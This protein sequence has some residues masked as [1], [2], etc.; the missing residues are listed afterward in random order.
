MTG[1]KGVVSDTLDSLSFWVSWSWTY[2]LMLWFLLIM[3]LIWFLRA[4]LR[5]HENLDQLGFFMNSLTPKFYVALTGTSSVISGIILIFEWW[6]FH[7]HGN[8]LIE[9]LALTYVAPFIGGIDLPE[10]PAQ[11]ECKVWRNPMNL[12]RGCEYFK[13]MQ[14]TGN[15]PLTHYDMNLTAQDQQMFFCP[16]VAGAGDKGDELM[17]LAWRTVDTEK[18]IELALQAVNGNSNCA[19]AY[20]LLAEEC[21]STVPEADK[22]FRQAL[23]IADNNIRKFVS[24]PSHDVKA[25]SLHRRD[26][27][28]C[29]YARRRV[30]MCL[31]KMGKL[32]ECIKITREL[33]K[34]FPL[35]SV[36]HIHE[37]L[38]EALL[39]QKAY[40]D[41]QALL[42]RYD[43]LTLPKSAVI[44][45]SAALLKIRPVCE[46]FFA[47]VTVK[48]GLTTH[49]FDA[50]EALQRAVEFNPH[51]PQYL[52]EEKP[53]ILPPEHLLKRGDS[54]AVAYSFYHAA[55]WKEVPG[56]IKF[57][58]CFW[59][60]TFKL[61]PFPLEKGKLFH[62]YTS[63]TEETDREL[64]PLF[65]DV[66]VYPK[67]ELP[68][69]LVFTAGL[70][71][72]TLSLALLTHFYPIFMG[73]LARIA[74]EY[75]ATPFAMIAEH[76]QALL[77]QQVW[78]LLTRA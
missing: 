71:L 65:H 30:A 49:Q 75:F 63:G 9:Q 22:Y 25:N 20:I 67:K 2:L 60:D 13:F 61:I 35:M 39:A 58:E 52:L 55:H 27:N 62:P 41:V 16:D 24:V 1:N 59:K 6:Y 7:K 42:T 29:V 47:D 72:F 14:V 48:K 12:I 34:E 44:C 56:S 45:Y 10:K 8:S 3:F 37:N 17:A 36:L 11:S 46:K 26:I 28:I 38:I 76:L 69:F 70:C 51:V 23:K 66:S 78:N 19:S 5:L 77:P 74:L 40:N 50:V 53:I 73:E 21:A 54:E 64:L 33:I 15:S 31:R 32:K 57:L 4:P 18:S 43:D 68:F